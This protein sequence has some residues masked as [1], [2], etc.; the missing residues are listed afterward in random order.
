[1][2]V[3]DATLPALNVPLRHDRLTVTVVPSGAAGAALEERLTAAFPMVRLESR[4]AVRQEALAIF[5]RTFAITRALTLLALLVAAVGMYNA[6]TAL[7]LQQAPTLALLHAQ[8]LLAGE[9]RRIGLW[10]CLAAGALAVGLALPLGIA[11]AWTLCAVIN[12][13]SFGWTVSLALPPSGWI[14]PVLLGLMA[15]VL[16]GLLPAP[17][18][19]EASLAAA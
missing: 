10:R 16:A 19:R 3:D 12:P 6:L 7:R 18:E 14:L 15:A 13:R 11:M 9:A 8:G 5:D 2:Q 1:M 17:T 4:Q